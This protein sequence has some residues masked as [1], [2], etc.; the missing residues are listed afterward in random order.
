GDVVFGE[1]FANGLA[2]NN[3]IG[4]WTTAEANGNLWLRT[5]TG[6]NGAFSDNT[7]KIVSTTQLN[8]WMI[9]NSDSANADWS[10]PNDPTILPAA[11]L[12]NWN[13][14]LVSPLL[15]LSAT[16]AV[17]VEFQQRL[18]YCC[19]D[20]PNFLQVSTDGGTSWPFTF[21]CA[22]GIDD[23]EDDGTMTKRINITAAIAADPT[24]VKFRFFHNGATSGS[25]H[26]HWQIDDVK[27]TTT[28][29]NDLRI[30]DAASFR[31]DP[32]TSAT[33]DSIDY[34]IIPTAQL[35]ELALNITAF[36]NGRVDQDNTTAHFRVTDAGGNSVFDQ[37]VNGGTIAPGTSSTIFSTGF[38][39]PAVTGEY[40]VHYALSSDSTDM[41]PADNVDSTTFAVSDNVYARDDDARDGTGSNPNDNDEPE[42]F[43]LGN[44][45][46][47][48][49]DATVYAVDIS[50]ATGTE[51]GTTVR[52][53]VRAD[54]LDDVL[55]E[56]EDHVITASDLTP[57]GG[58]R[59]IPFILTSA[60]PVEAGTD[61]FAGLVHFGGADV[62]C[63]TS[64]QSP[65]Q[66][67]FLFDT[68]ADT[69]FFVTNTPMVRLNF[70]SH[71]GIEERDVQN[72]VGL[73]Q[74]VPNPVVNSTII[75]YS[76]TTAAKVTLDIY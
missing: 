13:A 12:I 32:S 30:T 41:V 15:D 34:T 54:N 69:W 26:Y 29:M 67:S 52:A 72:G 64:G 27:I 6:P 42:A 33:W 48:A 37:D 39:P 10:D 21:P 7:E 57:N 31:F 71:V 23:N 61:I 8:G 76:L 18:R 51:V 3:G 25:S 5:T 28:P 70:N 56:S 45:F 47:I 1:D 63:S 68:P 53:Q 17:Q 60:L 59:M 36:N 65:E 38:V 49:N 16:P 50:L 4:A 46:H 44:G 20:A 14:A 11:Q 55:A 73:G 22:E 40:E 74:N 43:I 58:H 2:G 19:A 75:P 9:L 35:R 24:N 66:T 62:L